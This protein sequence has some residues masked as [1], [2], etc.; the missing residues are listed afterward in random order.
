MSRFRVVLLALAATFALGALFAEV[1]SAETTLLAEWLANGAAITSSLSGEISGSYKL[2]DTETIA[3]KAAVTCSWVERTVY[4]PNGGIIKVIEW[5]DLGGTT[6]SLSGVALLGTGAGSDCRAVSGCAEGTAASPIEVDPVG[7]PWEGNL[8]L[9]ENGELLLLVNAAEVGYEIL[10]LILG[11]NAEDK[12]TTTDSEIKVENNASTGDA[13]TPANSGI[14][15]NIKCTQSGGKATGIIET[16]EELKM[17]LTS[18]ELLTVSS[19]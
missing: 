5:V 8:F 12:C 3:G 13:S 15:P 4:L 17:S 16:I 7:L 18:G 11:I 10:C 19:E 9:M 6:V 14:T 1:A 2:E